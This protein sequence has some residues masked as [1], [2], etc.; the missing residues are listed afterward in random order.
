MK[1]ILN[2]E[3]IIALI[4]IAFAAAVWIEAGRW[5]ESFLDAVGPS[6]YPRLLA[7]AIAA[8]SIIMFVSSK[9]AKPIKG[10]CHFFDLGYLIICIMAY[11]L[12]FPR[13][14]FIIGTTAFLLAMTLH[15]DRREMKVKIKIAVPYAVIFSIFLYFFFGKLLGV[16]LPSLIL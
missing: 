11:L 14:G 6:K 3:R 12:L 16:L 5:P 15:F 13:V 8:I 9:E 10:K 1:K 4:C 2:R 7:G